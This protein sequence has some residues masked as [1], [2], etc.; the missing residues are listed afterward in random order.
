[1]RRLDE[2]IASV[3]H[4]Q[5][6]V[7]WQEVTI[8]GIFHDTVFQSFYE[9]HNDTQLGTYGENNKVSSLGDAKSSLGDAKSS[10]GDAKSSLS[11]AKSSQGD[12]KSYLGDAEI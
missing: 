6:H 1:V 12:D 8:E 10:L 4:R 7:A 11:D 5:I 3:T 2:Y 9:T